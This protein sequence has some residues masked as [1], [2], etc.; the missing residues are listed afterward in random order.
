MTTMFLLPDINVWLAL[1]FGSHTHHSFV[2]LIA[3]SLRVLRAFAVQREAG[4]GV[5]TH[6]LAGVYASQ[7]VQWHLRLSEMATDTMLGTLAAPFDYQIPNRTVRPQAANRFMVGEIV[8]G[9][10]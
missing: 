6:Q 2:L 7:I 3:F 10:R 9:R 1:A 4:G 8:E 5:V